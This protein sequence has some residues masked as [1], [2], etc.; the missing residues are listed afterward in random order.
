MHASMS[1]SRHRAERPNLAGLGSSP[2]ATNRQTLRVER[3]KIDATS[4]T[5]IMR[6]TT[7]S[8]DDEGDIIFPCRG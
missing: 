4:R 2:L 8:E 5:L 1:A 7:E 3:L 6:G